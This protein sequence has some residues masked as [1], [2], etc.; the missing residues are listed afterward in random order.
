YLV[1]RPG[2]WEGW[3]LV[4]ES[5]L[6]GDGDAAG[7]GFVDAGG[8]AEQGGLARAVR[9]EQGGALPAGDDQRD[10]GEHAAVRERSGDA[11]EAEMAG[12]GDA[13]TEQGLGHADADIRRRTR[14][15]PSPWCSG[16]ARHAGG[17]AAAVRSST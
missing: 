12:A 8:D 6:A 13:G 5:H 3:L 16:V 15:G 9:A 17:A 10:I 2:E 14:P 11:V 1:D 7:V 4:E